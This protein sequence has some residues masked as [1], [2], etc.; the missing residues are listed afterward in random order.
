MTSGRHPICRQSDDGMHDFNDTLFV[1]GTN[2]PTVACDLCGYR[3]NQRD[4]VEI[5]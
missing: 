5:E 4:Y 2:E 3:P 1:K